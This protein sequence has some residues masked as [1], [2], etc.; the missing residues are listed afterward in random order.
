[1]GLK[2]G[3]I[4]PLAGAVTGDG[5]L[6]DA[7]RQGFGGFI[8]YAVANEAHDNREEKRKKEL[9]MKKGGAVKSG[10]SKRGDGIAQRGKTR[11]RMV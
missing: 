1:M 10:A 5:L 7:M 11:G 8:P 3:D 9:G 6:G 2:L 4:S